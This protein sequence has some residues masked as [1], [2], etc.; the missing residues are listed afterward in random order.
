MNN[1]CAVMTSPNAFRMEIRDI[2]RILE[3]E[4]LIQV[5]YCGICGSDLHLFQTGKQGEHIAENPMV[6]GHEAA[7]TV[8]ETG[9][10]VTGFSFGDSVAIEPGA[11]C[12]T[13]G[14]CVTGKYNLCQQM[15]FPSTPPHDGYFMQYIKVPEN[16]VYKLPGN[17]STRTGALLEPLACGLNA[18]AQG[19][20]GIGHSVVVIGAGCIGLMAMLACKARG[21]TNII[22]T[23]V[24]EQRLAFASE[25]GASHSIHANSIDIAAQ[26][27]DLTR[28]GAD[29]VIDCSGTQIG[30]RQTAEFVK[31]GGTI[32]LMGMPPQDFTEYNFTKLIWKEA[33][34]KTSLRYRNRFPSAIAS[35]QTGL[36]DLD[37]II[38]HE[39]T[40]KKIAEGFDYVARNKASVIKAIIKVS[41]DGNEPS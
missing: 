10:N 37:G 20:V 26:V 2:P 33:S 27:F 16:K 12:G 13:C 15:V 25:K 35:L 1:V 8:V 19:D 36:I 31:P 14:Y 6:L 24:F 7:G 11:N 17:I 18:A 34:V 38:T 3:N 28:G 30:Q 32:V 4:V 29:V 9:R 5:D 39:F 23:D 22:V 40:L 21:A 41:G